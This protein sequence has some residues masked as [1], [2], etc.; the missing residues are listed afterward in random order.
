M[1]WWYFDNVNKPEGCLLDGGIYRLWAHPHFGRWTARLAYPS[2]K[3]GL[4]IMSVA[5]G[6]S[7]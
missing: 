5:W 4:A 2:K 1:V 3:P 7:L 6:Y